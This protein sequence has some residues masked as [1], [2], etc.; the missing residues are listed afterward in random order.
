MYENT[1][2]LKLE[3]NVLHAIQT[4]TVIWHGELERLGQVDHIQVEVF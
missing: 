2:R 3:G 4:E 1:Q